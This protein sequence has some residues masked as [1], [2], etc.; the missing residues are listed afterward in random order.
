MGI[1][2]SRVSVDGDAAR[3][4]TADLPSVQQPDV[5]PVRAEMRLPSEA[6]RIEAHRH[7][8]LA[9]DKRFS[10]RGLGKALLVEALATALHVANEVGCRAVITDAY[11]HKVSWYERYGF[12]PLAAEPKS[13]QMKMYLDVRT[14][15]QASSLQ[16]SEEG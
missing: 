13:A 8:R 5:P 15:R 6:E 10:G 11:R 14:I 4:P 12:I 3:R 2:A 16:S 9:V 1:D 7:A